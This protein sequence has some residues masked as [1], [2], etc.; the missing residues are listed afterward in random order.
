MTLIV[1]LESC[2]SISNVSLERVAKT[3]SVL[4]R[5]ASITIASNARKIAIVIL[6]S[7]VCF[8]LE[9]VYQETVV[10][11]VTATERFA[12]TTHVSTARQMGSVVQESSVTQAPELVL[13]GT[14]ASMLIVL[15]ARFATIICA[16]SV[17]P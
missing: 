13:Q 10:V 1:V 7:F 15:V 9:S 8:P 4:P 11:T 5:H 2:V 16:A 12:K 3:A 14:V 17:H 6:D